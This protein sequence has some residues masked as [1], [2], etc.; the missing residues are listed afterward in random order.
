MRILRLVALVGVVLGVGSPVAAVPP[1]DA[2][3]TVVLNGQVVP[4]GRT[5]TALINDPD[6]EIVLYLEQSGSLFGEEDTT[7][8]VAMTV[9]DVV[10]DK[11]GFRSYFVRAEGVHYY[12]TEGQVYIAGEE[13]PF[14]LKLWTPLHSAWGV[15]VSQAPPAVR[16]EMIR[17]EPHSFLPC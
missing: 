17:Y 3:V 16:G 7:A 10:V 12:H 11:T 4:P 1:P 2:C 9:N 6:F 13:V 8:T 15:P 14:C 5:C